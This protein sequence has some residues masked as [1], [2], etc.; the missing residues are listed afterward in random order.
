MDRGKQHP[1]GRLGKP[2]GHRGEMA[3]VLHHADYDDIRKAKFLFVELD[4]LLVPFPVI[5]MRE[6]PRA[7]VL[8]K[9]EDLGDPQSVAFLVNASVY[10]APGPALAFEDGEEEDEE[11]DW[12]ADSLLG[13]Q[14]LDEELGELGTVM[15][16]DG[17]D[18][19]PLLVVR[20]QGR[21]ILIPMADEIITGIDLETGH[22]VVRT[23]PGLVDLYRNG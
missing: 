14:V 15:R 22:L 23:P 8:V 18:D 16:L 2:W 3:L 1:I 9:F 10:A 5:G 11:D 20:H 19:N 7:G 17:V 21:E 4:G 12:D 6:H 13:L